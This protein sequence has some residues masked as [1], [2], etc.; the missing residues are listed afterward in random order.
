MFFLKNHKYQGEPP[1]FVH[2]SKFA[3]TADFATSPFE[4]AENIFR[5]KTN[6]KGSKTN[7]I[8]SLVFDCKLS[9]KNIIN[10][11]YARL[12]ATSSS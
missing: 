1:N 11:N 10:K 12:Q 8:L 6:K 7:Q 5:E 2:Q 9:Q 3:R 4:E